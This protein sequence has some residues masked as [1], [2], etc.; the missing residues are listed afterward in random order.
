MAQATRHLLKRLLD[1][2]GG[3]Q[4]THHFRQCVWSTSKYMDSLS[5]LYSGFQQKQSCRL[6]MAFK[7]NQRT[8]PMSNM[9][10]TR[11]DQQQKQQFQEGSS[12]TLFHY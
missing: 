9:P 1:D 3:D 10:M 4:L 5:Q 12:S 7:Y 8:I 11:V 6:R 2:Q